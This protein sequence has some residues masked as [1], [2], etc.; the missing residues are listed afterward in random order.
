M[1]KLDCKKR[2][3]G[4]LSMT[5]DGEPMGEGLLN[6]PRRLNDATADADSTA[7]SMRMV[8]SGTS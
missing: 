2:L 7:M 8:E 1:P 5:F 6:V 4:D 3:V